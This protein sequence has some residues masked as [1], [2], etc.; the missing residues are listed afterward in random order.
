MTNFGNFSNHRQWREFIAAIH[1][2]LTTAGSV[3]YP[4]VKRM[5]ASIAQGVNT[6]C[7]ALRAGILPATARTPAQD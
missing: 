7:T 5:S 6:H 4:M 3:T 1:D 2:S